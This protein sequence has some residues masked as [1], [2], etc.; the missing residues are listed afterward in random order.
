[1]I[2]TET[3]A[4]TRI[5]T[6]NRPARRNAVDSLTAQ[7]L[8]EAFIQFDTDDTCDVAIRRGGR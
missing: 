4:R 8:F 6:I 2:T 1:M 7:A 3:A 5:I